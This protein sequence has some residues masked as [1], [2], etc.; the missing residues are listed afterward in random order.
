MLFSWTD[1]SVQLPDVLRVV[2]VIIWLESSNLANFNNRLSE[3][4][5]LVPCIDLMLQNNFC[6]ELQCK[7]RKQNELLMCELAQLK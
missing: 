6:M 3:A 1:C 7:Q 2:G 4:V 5:E